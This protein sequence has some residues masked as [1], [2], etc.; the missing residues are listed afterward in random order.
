LTRPGT[1]ALKIEDLRFRHR[2]TGGPFVA[3]GFNDTVDDA[4][5]ALFLRVGQEPKIFFSTAANLCR[6]TNESPPDP[7]QPHRAITAR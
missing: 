1:P 4:A 3:P 5:A 2:L 7:A 6:K